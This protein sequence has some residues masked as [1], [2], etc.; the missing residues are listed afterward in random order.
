MY[1]FVLALVYRSF[2]KIILYELIIETLGVCRCINSQYGCNKAL[3]LSLKMRY[4]TYIKGI[5]V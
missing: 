5:A 2:E 4:N 1:I 3:L